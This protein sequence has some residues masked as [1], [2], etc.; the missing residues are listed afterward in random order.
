MISKAMILAAGLGTRLSSL[1]F[2]KPKALVEVDGI[3]ML[4][5]LLLKLKENGFKQVMI[6]LHHHASQIKESVEL[7]QGFGLDVF[8]SDET[9][10]L[11]DTGGA[12][13]KAR[14]FFTG[15]S[16]ILVHNADILTNL[17]LNDLLQFHKR[18]HAKAS[19]FVSHRNSGRAL[20]FNARNELKGWT[21]VSTNSFKWTDGEQK[22]CHP[23]AFNGIWLAEP[24][25][26]QHLPFSGRFSIIDAWL[27]MA[28][29][30]K[31]VGFED[32]SA[33][34]FDMGTPEKIAAAEQFLK[35]D[36][37]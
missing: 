25:F 13:V 37:P 8:F 35:L 19:L 23:L 9:N 22:N 2:N 11:L 28:P 1:T 36:T 10:E 20:L 12:L 15:D 6:N 29:G 30:H 16:P 5:R 7:N 17:N 27:A 33:T 3:P 14:D 26:I 4:H 31:I 24:D 18:Q 32:N 21:N 34:W